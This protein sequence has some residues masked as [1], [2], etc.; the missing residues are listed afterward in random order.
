MPGPEEDKTCRDEQVAKENPDSTDNPRGMRE[1][2]VTG[3]RDCQLMQI[4]RVTNNVCD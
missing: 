1:E 3:E 2:G 4:F